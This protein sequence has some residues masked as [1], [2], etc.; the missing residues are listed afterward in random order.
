MMRNTSPVDVLIFLWSVVVCLY[1]VL[2]LP[3]GDNAPLNVAQRHFPEA[4]KAVAF[5]IR[6]TAV[7]SS[8]RSLARMSD[9]EKFFIGAFG[10]LSVFGAVFLGHRS[11]QKAPASGRQRRRTG[12]PLDQTVMEWERNEPFSIRN[13]LQSVAVFGATGSGKSSGSAKTIL[14]SLIKLGRQ[15]GGTILGAKPEDLAETQ[16]LFRAAGRLDDLLVFSPESGHTCNYMDFIVKL[17]GHDAREVTKFLNVIKE[18]LQTSE[19]KG[20]GEMGDFWATAQEEQIFNAVVPVL[21]AEGELRPDVL[22]DF[23]L[24]AAHD[25]AQFDDPKWREGLHNTVLRKAH[26]AVKRRTDILDLEGATKYWTRQYPTLAEKTRS[27]VDFGTLSLLNTYCRGTVR[28]M[29][30]EQ[31]SFSPVRSLLGH[32]I[33]CDMSPAAYGDGGIVVNAGLKYLCQRM[34]LRREFTPGDTVHVLWMDEAQQFINSGNDSHYLA[35]CRS[36]GACMICISQALPSYY[37][38]LKGENGK[39][40]ANALLGNFGTKLLHSLGDIE[41]ATWAANL[42]GK[43]LTPFIGGSSQANDDFVGQLFGTTQQT[44]SYSTQFEYTLQPNVFLNGSLRTGGPANQ[45][46]TDAVLIRSEPFRDGR[47]WKFVTFSQR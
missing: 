2:F 45:L 39:Q 43:E 28:Q 8:A 27:C 32:W 25:P 35:Q 44:T 29:I 31:T 22:R 41:T 23:I 33:F 18:S 37:S 5:H 9:E 47:N 26:R 7:E 4:C 10:V 12:N 46:M 21:L 42:I 24:G 34:L 14:W 15:V 36:H 30:A 6:G 16:E 20:G 17:G 11:R 1:A 38:A 19:T 13:L 40:H 3:S